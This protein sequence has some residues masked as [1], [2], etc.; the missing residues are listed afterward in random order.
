MRDK[1]ETER[2]WR[3]RKTVGLS[4]ASQF[5]RVGG[6]EVYSPK[7]IMLKKQYASRVAIEIKERPS[8][9]EIALERFSKRSSAP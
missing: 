7:T 8:D 1:V 6:A 3:V 4:E 5:F 2:K 9:K